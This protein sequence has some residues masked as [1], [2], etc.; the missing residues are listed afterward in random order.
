MTTI[1]RTLTVLKH[2]GKIT[3]IDLSNEAR[4]YFQGDGELRSRAYG[5]LYTNYASYAIIYRCQDIRKFDKSGTIDYHEEYV[6]ILTRSW[7]VT[8]NLEKEIKKKVKQFK[9]RPRNLE[10]TYGG[11]ASQTCLKWEKERNKKKN[12]RISSGRCPDHTAM[13]NL[14]HERY[15]GDWREYKRFS[16]LPGDMKCARHN[17]Y[18]SVSG[19][20][21]FAIEGIAVVNNTTETLKYAGYMLPFVVKGS[22]QSARFRFQRNNEYVPSDMPPNYEILYTD[23]QRYSI[24]Y[25]CRDFQRFDG[26][27]PEDFHEQNYLILIR[28]EVVLSP[29]L[30]QEMNKKVRALG[31][32]P[33]KLKKIYDDQNCPKK[34]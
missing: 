10:T 25:G 15:I 16:P 6:F 19:S 34:K 5:I 28:P 32:K 29:G 18:L 9:L 1:N 24:V 7:L 33:R 20:F 2:K 31:L 22:K 8:R 30:E 4:Y 21:G 26:L 12:K 3:K 13:S 11:I 17:Y 23:Y 14:E 27:S